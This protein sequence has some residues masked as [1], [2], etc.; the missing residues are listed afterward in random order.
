[1]MACFQRRPRLLRALEVVDNRAV[2]WRHESG[3]VLLLI[4]LLGGTSELC[5]VRNVSSSGSV[6][7][8]HVVL[9]L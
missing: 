2:S 4:P 6:D 1:M 8:R 9:R 7:V 5:I 3:D